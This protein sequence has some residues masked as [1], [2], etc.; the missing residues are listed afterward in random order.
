MTCSTS[1]MGAQSP[2]EK[3]IPHGKVAIVSGR[4]LL[5]DLGPAPLLLADPAYVPDLL[6]EVELASKQ[7][8]QPF[9]RD[10]AQVLIVNVDDGSYPIRVLK[11]DTNDI[12]AIRVD[13]KR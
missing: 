4:L 11:D 10:I 5:A 9:L 6:G 8:A 2:G 3:W 7:G 1:D 13:L 12:V